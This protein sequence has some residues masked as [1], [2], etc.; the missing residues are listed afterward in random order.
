MSQHRRHSTQ[1][2][3]HSGGSVIPSGTRYDIVYDVDGSA[4]AVISDSS[5]SWI[6]EYGPTIIL[7]VIIAYV[8]ATRVVWRLIQVCFS[9]TIFDPENRYFEDYD[10]D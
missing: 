10:E 6:R 4:V 1:I 7:A 9:H 8:V 3:E 5:S 2:L